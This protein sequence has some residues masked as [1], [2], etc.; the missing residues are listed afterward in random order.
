MV[1]GEVG[2]S[3]SAHAA[4]CGV[5]GRSRLDHVLRVLL[6]AADVERQQIPDLQQ[7]VIHRDLM[8]VEAGGDD[9]L[10]RLVARDEILDLARE[11]ARRPR[12]RLRDRAVAR[13][14]EPGAVLADHEAGVAVDVGEH[15]DR[16]LIGGKLRRR[17]WEPAD[18]SGLCRWLDRDTGWSR[19]AASRR[20]DI[21][22]RASSTR[23][24]VA[25]RTAGCP[26]ARRTDL[27][28]W[29]GRSA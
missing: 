26:N 14:P 3:F 7:V 15:V 27:P 16:P 18:S 2:V 4:A 11:L 5:R 19:S 22:R 28:A 9:V 20:R 21:A 25:A 8:A 23:R 24:A 12:R 13:L 17:R 10:A 1:V 6:V 29:H